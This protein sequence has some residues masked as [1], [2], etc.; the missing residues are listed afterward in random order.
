MKK[1]ETPVVEVAELLSTDVI[2]TSEGDT[3]LFAYAW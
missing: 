2:T 1:Y 3:P